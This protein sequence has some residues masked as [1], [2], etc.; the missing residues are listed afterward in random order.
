MAYCW[1]CW[2]DCK[3]L[4]ASEAGLSRLGGLLPPG[5]RTPAKHA[6]HC[7]G[8]RPPMTPCEAW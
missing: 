5:G 8:N 7:S 3:A 2:G 6:L 4:F 1:V